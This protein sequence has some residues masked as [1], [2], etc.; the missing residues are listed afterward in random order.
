MASDESFPFIKGTALRSEKYSAVPRRM[1]AEF[2]LPPRNAGEHAKFIR[3]RVA[4]LSETVRIDS[5]KKITASDRKIISVRMTTAAGV[6]PELLEST[7]K[8]AQ[9]SLL[10]FDPQTGIALVDARPELRPLLQ[11]L[12]RY[13]KSLKD[14]PETPSNRKLINY[15]ED[16]RLAGFSEV[17]GDALRADWATLPKDMPI[18]LEFHVRGGYSNKIEASASKAAL[19]AA[20]RKQQLQSDL[21]KLRLQMPEEDVYFA[22]ISINAAAEVFALVDC[23][24]ELELPPQVALKW[25]QAEH[26]PTTVDPQLKFDSLSPTAPEV[27]LLDSG[28]LGEHPLLKPVIS[29]VHSALENETGADSFGHG[30]EMAGVAV[31]GQQ[32]PDVLQHGRYAPEARIRSVQLIKAPGQ[33][34]ALEEM[35]AAWPALTEKAV[36]I[37]DAG[38]VNVKQVFALAITAESKFGDRA[39]SWTN[40][41]DKAAYNHCLLYT[42]DA[43]DE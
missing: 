37:A 33:G 43:A 42:S 25:L 11:K 17:V 28:L 20:F 39:S 27:V 3:D 32:L 18:W 14:K 41:V 23:I 12:D 13:E 38:A 31:Y 10:D 8:G 4:L 1:E 40:A 24:F 15:I 36:A 30:T 26:R 7:K 6:D 35:R 9:I 5:P 2:V 34:T 21:E 19:Q 29:G 22:L 16:I